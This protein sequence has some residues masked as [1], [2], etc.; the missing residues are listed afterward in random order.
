[1]LLVPAAARAQ[2]TVTLLPTRDSVA[3]GDILRVNVEIVSTIGS[4]EAVS[5]LPATGFV[6][7]GTMQSQSMEF[8]FGF[9]TGPQRLRLVRT[10]TLQAQTAGVQTLGPVQV[11][12]GSQVFASGTVQIRVGP[13][14]GNQAIPSPG[15]PTPL[16]PVLPLSQAGPDTDEVPFSVC[17]MPDGSQVPETG[18]DG[19]VTC[20]V[21]RSDVFLQV[22]VTDMRVYLG[23]PLR[24][25]IRA[26]VERD[27]VGFSLAQLFS[28][29]IRQ[30]PS[31]EG[32][33]RTNLEPREMQVEQQVVQ[34]R[35]YVWTTLRDK[36]LY[37]TRAGR[38]EIGAAEGVLTVPDFFHPREIRRGSAPVPIEVLPLPL[39]GR[40][41]DFSPN[42]VGAQLTATLDAPQQS[43]QVGQSIEVTLRLAGEGNLAGFQVPTPQ[44][45]GATVLKSDDKVEEPTADRLT[46]S[47]T[48][49][50]LITPSV[51]GTLDLSVL[52]VPYFDFIE[53][54]YAVARPAVL[55]VAVAPAPPGTPPP[56]GA[57][58][59]GPAPLASQPTASMRPWNDLTRPSA[60]WHDHPLFWV[61]FLL[62]PASLA[63][64][65]A[66]TAAAGA[67]R[68]RRGV[69]RPG[70]V[71]RRSVAALRRVAKGRGAGDAVAQL[72]A[73]ESA[74]LDYLEARMGEPLRGYATAELQ[75]RMVAAGF[76]EALVSRL[77]AQLET[78]AFGRFAPSSS[79]QQGASDAARGAFDVLRDL[80]R[81]K[82]SSTTETRT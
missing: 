17:R 5:N 1:V 21:I 48:I 60:P 53:E 42:N 50:F 81:A 56:A 2:V 15:L 51:P 10:F 6:Q 55:R 33:L 8:S 41:V 72:G 61:L 30:E 37:P 24:L 65:F 31:L 69:V 46:G 68:R 62:P 7:L 79:R 13:G 18:A 12:V 14:S 45:P 77:V 26:F 80:E 9:G 44:L 75:R 19:P 49:S 40:P 66:V 67:L 23:E 11:Q 82:P 74:L 78:C 36:L 64:L 25:Q 54:R 39:A 35:L 34:G 4:P 28:Q 27:M 22:E 70:D 73:V 3:V 71:Y 20:T 59:G 47:R 57:M 29:L 43:L 63:G 58:P 76:A 32:F 38:L 16:A 52:F